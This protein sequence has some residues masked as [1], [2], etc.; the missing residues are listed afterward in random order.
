MFSCGLKATE[1]V[2]FFVCCLR[3]FL[4]RVWQPLVLVSLCMCTAGSYCY[5]NFILVT[6]SVCTCFSIISNNI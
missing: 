5:I 1:F 3:M 2:C 6:P 4:N